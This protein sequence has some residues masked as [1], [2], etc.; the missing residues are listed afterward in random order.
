MCKVI[1]V[2]TRHVNGLKS[3]RE[4]STGFNSKNIVNSL[5]FS[6]MNFND[7]YDKQQRIING[8]TLLEIKQFREYYKLEL[9]S[10]NQIIKNKP[11]SVGMKKFLKGKRKFICRLL[12][13]SK[14]KIKEINRFTNN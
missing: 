11:L 7:F 2:E 9:K 12:H 14:Q 10:L 5:F 4:I 1:V 8:S 3:I 6:D 13:F